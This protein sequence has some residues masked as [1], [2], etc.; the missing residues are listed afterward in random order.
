MKNLQKYEFQ[1]VRVITRDGTTYKGFV[2]VYTSAADNDDM[3]ESIG[4]MP[5]RT[6][7]SG[8]ELFASDIQAIEILN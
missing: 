2:D 8:V 4:L 1:N 5:T 3:E 6:A 7:N